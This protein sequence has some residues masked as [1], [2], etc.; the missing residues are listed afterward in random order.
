MV[1]SLLEATCDEEL[2]LVAHSPLGALLRLPHSLGLRKLI[3]YAAPGIG[4]YRMPLGLMAAAIPVQPQTDQRNQ[5]RFERWAFRDADRTR[6]QDEHWF[7]AF[8]AY[9]VACGSSPHVKRTMRQLVKTGTKRVP[10][11]ALRRVGAA[12][13]PLGKARSDGSAACRRG[14]A[15]RLGWPSRWSTTPV[16]YPTSSSPMRFWRHST[17]HC[18]DPNQS[19]ERRNSWQPSTGYAA[20]DPGVAGLEGERVRLPSDQ[21]RELESKLEGSMLCAGDEGWDEAVLVWNALVTS[22]PALVVQP[23]SARDVSATVDFARHHALLL[24]I[25]VGATTSRERQSRTAD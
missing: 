6:R 22:S 19:A 10:D 23:A 11:A 14:A 5:E 1:R 12:G 3:V 13:T 2:A 15:S 4:P 18:T 9:T 8:D 20:L 17:A 25:K 24:S 7:E 16:T 21:L